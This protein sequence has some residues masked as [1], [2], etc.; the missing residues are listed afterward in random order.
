MTAPWREGLPS[1]EAMR[2]AY[3]AGVAAGKAGADRDPAHESYLGKTRAESA[4]SLSYNHG[5]TDGQQIALQD[6]YGD[7]PSRP[8]P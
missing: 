2:S 4:L 7:P 8:A 6:K 1:A 3:R 5:Y